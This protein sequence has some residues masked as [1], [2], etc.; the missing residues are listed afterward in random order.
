MSKKFPR[1]K[2]TFR[3]WDTNI[4]HNTQKNQGKKLQTHRDTCAHIHH[5]EFG[6]FLKN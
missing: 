4:S 2:E 6:N 1:A 5:G 3:S